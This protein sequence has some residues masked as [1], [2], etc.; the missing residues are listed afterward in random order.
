MS[1]AK[2]STW[3][4]PEY[5]LPDL[6]T[7][8]R[9][10]KP[11]GGPKVQAELFPASRDNSKAGR[12]ARLLNVSGVVLPSNLAAELTAW[13]RPEPWELPGGEAAMAECESVGRDRNQ[14]ENRP[15]AK[16]C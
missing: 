6:A 16:F 7:L 15:R 2:P 11:G 13:S 4:R 5:L 9:L 12:V 10:S 3:P 14:Q 8:E 1:K